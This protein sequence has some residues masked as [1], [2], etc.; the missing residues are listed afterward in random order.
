[1]SKKLIIS[2]SDKIILK[3]KALAE[4]K[5]SVLRIKT[6]IDSMVEGVAVADTGMHF[7]LFNKSAERILGVGLLKEDPSKWAKIYGVYLPDQKTLLPVDQFPLKKALKGEIVT[8]FLQYVKNN[9]RKKGLYIN[10][11]A[12]PLRDLNGRITG[13]VAVFRDV[14]KEKE[15]DKAKTKQLAVTAKEKEDVRLKLVVTAEKLAVTTKELE[16]R[17]EKLKIIFRVLPVGVAVLDVESKVVYDNHAL[18]SMLGMTEEGLFRGDYEKRTYL[19]SDGS[20]MVPA[21]EFASAR[22]MKEQRAVNNIET[23]VVK[24]DGSIVWLSVNAIPVK[25]SDWKMLVV[26]MDITERKKAY[27]ELKE[28]QE[29]LS[30]LDK[31]ASLGKL[32]GIVGHELRNPLG[33]IRNSVYFLRLKLDP[34]L[35]DEKIKRHLEMMDQEINNSDRIINDIL[36]FSRIKQPIFTQN[37]LNKILKASLKKVT[38]NPNIKVET[39]LA[40]LPFIP[41]DENQLVQVFT[42]IILNAAESMPKGGKLTISSSVKQDRDSINVSIKDTGEGI[43]KENLRKL[44][45]PL[46]STKINGTGLGMVVCKSI[47]ENHKGYIR[48][49]SE[50]DKGTLVTVELPIKQT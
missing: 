43:S 18:E 21:E 29:K 8:G 30:R 49:E 40:E 17:E 37:N 6:I 31:L 38:I 32:A 23:G 41:S 4:E 24:E 28:T 11:T 26:S 9:Q 10:T 44:F 45:E 39:E 46:F 25:F 47:I 34:A 27:D 5:E 2:A 14:S 7:E 12:S 48:V 22:A 33:A 36:F 20:I 19:R 35:Q 13:A 42:N 3:L 1:M 50:E 16:E 15:I